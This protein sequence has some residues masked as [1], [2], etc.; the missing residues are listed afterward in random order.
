MLKQLEWNHLSIATNLRVFLNW[1]QS[2]NDSLTIF[3]K[4]YACVREATV[5]EKTYQRRQAGSSDAARI[6]LA[7][8]SVIQLLASVSYIRK[9]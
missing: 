7:G 4:E 2:V 5:V 8:F 6:L 1:F 9:L 3:V